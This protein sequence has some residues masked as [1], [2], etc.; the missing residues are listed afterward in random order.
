MP[1]HDTQILVF[2]AH[3]LHVTLELNHRLRLFEAIHFRQT[4]RHNELLL[5]LGQFNDALFDVLT[6]RELHVR[7]VV[8]RS[9]AAALVL[10]RFL[11]AMHTG[12]R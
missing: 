12:A 4:D 9:A 2:L 3:R 8:G 6:D 11:R 1:A 10:V 7:L 5:C